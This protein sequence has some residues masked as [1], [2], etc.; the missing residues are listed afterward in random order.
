MKLSHIL[1]FVGGAA[2]GVALGMLLAPDSGANTRQRIADSLH[3]KGVVLDRE[4][5][6]TFVDRVL[7]KLR[8]N[9]T[10]EELDLVVDATIN[11]K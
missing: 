1:A 9:F 11:E 5:L 2:A 7:A 6:K 4:S 8:E 10:D 3:A